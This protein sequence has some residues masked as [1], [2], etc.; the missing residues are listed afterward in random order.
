MNTSNYFLIGCKTYSMRW[1]PCWLLNETKN[2]TLD[3][4]MSL[5]ANLLNEY[6][7]LPE[8]FKLDNNPSTENRKWTESHS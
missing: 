8:E 5:R 2:L 1:N 3:R 6:I 4:P 7:L